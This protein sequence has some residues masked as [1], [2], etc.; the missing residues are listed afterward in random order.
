M[1]EETFEGV[2]GGPRRYM[3]DGEIWGEQHA[4]LTFSGG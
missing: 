4:C 3:I 2:K 1:K